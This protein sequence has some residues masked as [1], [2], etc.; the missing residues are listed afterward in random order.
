VKG[1]CHSRPRLICFGRLLKA[2]D[3]R[4]QNSKP[5]ATEAKPRETEPQAEARGPKRHETR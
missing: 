3:S 1:K 5:I 2:T 4:K